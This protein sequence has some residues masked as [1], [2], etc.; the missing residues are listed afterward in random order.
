MTTRFQRRE[1]EL[2]KRPDSIATFFK[3]WLTNIALGV[4]A[5]LAL[6]VVLAPIVYFSTAYAIELCIAFSILW[7]LVAIAGFIAWIEKQ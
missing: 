7:T 4:G 3:R 6:G 5:I 2:W 1:T